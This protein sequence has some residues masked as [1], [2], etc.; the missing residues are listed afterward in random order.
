LLTFHS[1]VP[2]RVE[3]LFSLLPVESAK[4]PSRGRLG[5]LVRHDA[6]RGC[7]SWLPEKSEARVLCEGNSQKAAAEGVAECR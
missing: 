7:G 5:E 4:P 6:Q 1:F 3:V 2:F